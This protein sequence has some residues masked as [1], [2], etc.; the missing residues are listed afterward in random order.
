MRIIM[1]TLLFFS[2]HFSQ[3]STDLVTQ[4]IFVEKECAG[5]LH[6]LRFSVSEAVAFKDLPFERFSNSEVKPKYFHKELGELG[7]AAIGRQFLIQA[8]DGSYYTFQVVAPVI[9]G[10]WEHV[11]I[12]EITTKETFV[13]TVSESKEVFKNVHMVH[14]GDYKGVSKD[15]E[16]LPIETQWRDSAPWGGDVDDQVVKLRVQISNLVKSTNRKRSAYSIMRELRKTRLAERLAINAAGN[17]DAAEAM[18]KADLMPVYDAVIRLRKSKPKFDELLEKV[19]K[20]NRDGVDTDMEL[21]E[22]F[23]KAQFEVEGDYKVLGSFLDRYIDAYDYIFHE[24]RSTVNYGTTR[25]NIQLIQRKIYAELLGLAPTVEEVMYQFRQSPIP[26][27]SRLQ[28]RLAY[29]KRAARRLWRAWFSNAFFAT[30]TP[31]IPNAP[32]WVKKFY[33]WVKKDSLDRNSIEMYMTDI[34]R[35]RAHA[36][37][38]QVSLSELQENPDEEKKLKLQKSLL[39]EVRVLAASGEGALTFLYRVIDD[40]VL[41]WVREEIDPLLLDSEIVAHLNGFEKEVDKAKADALLAGDLK[42]EEKPK[43]R[44]LAKMLGAS[45]KLAGVWVLTDA[46]FDVFGV[47]LNLQMIMGKV[48]MDGIYETLAQFLN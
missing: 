16:R 7:Y 21:Y 43:Q 47:D 45:V 18:L 1:L 26:M 38:L 41:E 19:K 24:A 42:I 27:L 29:E 36:V 44:L 23:E 10:D 37:D 12:R 22:Q 17:L 3:A 30:H 6:P 15:E 9:D 8:P 11:V 34:V 2:A 25:R 46:G 28:S 31:S 14:S 4:P 33:L 40:P 5:Y 48:G 13:I 20:H 32:D 35:L 39:R